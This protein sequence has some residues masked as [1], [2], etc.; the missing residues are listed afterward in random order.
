MR[1][2]QYVHVYRYCSLVQ[3]Q[4]VCIKLVLKVDLITAYVYMPIGDR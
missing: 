3:Y 2:V 1:C 4:H